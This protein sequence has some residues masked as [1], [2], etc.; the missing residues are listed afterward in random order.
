MSRFAVFARGAGLEQAEAVCGPADEVGGDVLSGLEELADQSLLRRVPDFDE[1]RLL[2]LQTIREYGLERL[3]QSGEAAAI[4]D[5]HADAYCA[6]AAEAAPNV[7]GKDQR[8]WLDRLERDHDNFRAALDWCVSQGDA[9]R[10]M[11]LAA[12]FWRFWQMRGH[13]H[14]G[15]SRLEIVLALPSHS[16]DQQSR[17]QALEAAGGIAYWQ[18][19]MDA[20]QTFYDDCLALVRKGSDRKALANALYNAA[21]PRLVN[22]RDME[23]SYRIL[24]EALPIFRELDDEVGISNCQWALGNYLYYMGNLVE[25]IPALDEAIRLFRKRGNRFGLGWSL[26]TRALT[27]IKERDLRLAR[28]HVMEA[29]Q[30]FSEAGDIS[31]TVLL[32]DDAADV[33]RLE[34][35]RANSIRLA[36][37]AAAHQAA[38]GAGLGTILN[39][40]EKR[41]RHE[42]V[43]PDEEHIWQEGEAM[44]IEQ[45]VAFVLGRD[46]AAAPV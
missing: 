29:L 3:E 17:I 28:S 32:L 35:H 46:T 24:M 20:A 12:T 4:R 39:V 18:G 1:P 22:R 8:L 36:A 40:E 9:E 19:E 27:A 15:R 14:E 25:A 38:S 10:A 30:L 23:N 5:R 34:G 31:G 37:A 6:L 21:F 11:R 43:T 2:M 41:N 26:H 45:A 16:E 13:L 44:T 42:D 7:F 33:E